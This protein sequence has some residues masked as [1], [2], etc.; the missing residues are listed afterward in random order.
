M[1]RKKVSDTPVHDQVQSYTATITE[2]A[3]RRGTLAERV[4]LNDWLKK[5]VDIA[6]DPAELNLLKAMSEVI[7]NA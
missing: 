6:Q 3:I 2:L 1:A 7:N 4:R 5:Q